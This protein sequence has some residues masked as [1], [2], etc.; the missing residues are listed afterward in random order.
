MLSLSLVAFASQIACCCRL[1]CSSLKQCYLLENQKAEGT[2]SSCCPKPA[3]MLDLGDETLARQTICQRATFTEYGFPPCPLKWDQPPFQIGTHKKK[4]QI[5][6]ID[7]DCL[8]IHTLCLLFYLKHH[9]STPRTGLESQDPFSAHLPNRA[10][11]SK[12]LFSASLTFFYLPCW[13][14]G[15]A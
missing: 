5:S 9:I 12:P 13:E 10:T 14:S 7:K 3:I 6:H 1:T 2:E 15:W 8:V 11:P 4:S